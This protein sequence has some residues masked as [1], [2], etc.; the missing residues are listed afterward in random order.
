[1]NASFEAAMARTDDR[2]AAT[3]RL[4]RELAL[5]LH[6][7]EIQA[8]EQALADLRRIDER[9]YRAIQLQF[10]GGLSVAEIAGALQLSSDVVQRDLSKARAFLY[11]AVRR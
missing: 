11:R 10:L 9:C 5:D 7:A 8:L 1:M 4:S 6:A 2:D 3:A